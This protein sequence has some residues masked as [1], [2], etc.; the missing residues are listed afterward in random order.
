MPGVFPLNG[1][2]QLT[3]HDCPEISRW[4]YAPST[5]PTP[6]PHTPPHTPTHRLHTPPHTHPLHRT[7][8]HTGPST[9]CAEDSCSN[10]GVCLQQWEGFSC[11]CTMTSYGGTYCS[12]RKY[13]QSPASQ[14]APL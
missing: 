1:F 5:L 3:A 11:D 13:P 4:L 2:L 8:T 14:A 10:L 9:P 7:H 6:L 12:D